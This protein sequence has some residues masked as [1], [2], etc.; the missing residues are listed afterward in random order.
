MSTK[1]FKIN[2][3][4]S[5]M[6]AFQAIRDFWEEHK[7]I[8]LTIS[9]KRSL[10]MNALQ[11]QWYKIIA[12]H[13]GSSESEVKAFCKY[14]FGRGILLRNDLELADL[15]KSVDWNER[16]RRWNMSV[17]DSKVLALSKMEVTSTFSSSESIEYM[18]AMKSHYEP[19]GFTLPSKKDLE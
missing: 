13:T 18:D 17:E 14:H 4:S 3:L 16:A 2:C 19:Q 9:D 7:Y 11:H 15:L 10:S 12:T 5:L 8:Q 1:K 6:D